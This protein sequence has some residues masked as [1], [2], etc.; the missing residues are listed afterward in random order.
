LQIHSLSLT[1]HTSL[2][3]HLG[4]DGKQWLLSR[5]TLEP[6]PMCKTSKTAFPSLRGP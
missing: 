5:R 1:E 6:P 4:H 2:E 3:H